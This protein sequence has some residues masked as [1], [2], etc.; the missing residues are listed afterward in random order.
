MLCRGLFNGGFNVWRALFMGGF[1]AG[2]FVSAAMWP[3]A[4]DVLPATYTI[5]RA[6]LGGLLVGSGA[7]LG[8]GCTSGHGIAGNARCALDQTFRFQCCRVDV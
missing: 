2:A 5:P 8:N 6:V 1:L 7:T 3:G 4:F